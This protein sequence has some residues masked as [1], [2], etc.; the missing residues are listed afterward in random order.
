MHL[1]DSF[2]KFLK[3]ETVTTEQTSLSVNVMSYLRSTG[4]VELPIRIG[5]KGRIRLCGVYWFARSDNSRI[6][7]IGENVRVV[8][9]EGNTLVIEPINL[10]KQLDLTWPDSK[11][12]LTS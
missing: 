5:K 3:L 9:R 2:R 7:A 11:V 4:V 10:P 1:V 8:G 6:I 12:K